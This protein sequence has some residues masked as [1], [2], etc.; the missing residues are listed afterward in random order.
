MSTLVVVVV[1]FM[2]M[3]MMMMM[4]MVKVMMKFEVHMAAKIKNMIF[5]AV[6]VAVF[7]DRYQ[8]FRETRRLHQ[9]GL[10]VTL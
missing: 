2:M 5:R 10:R 8:H 1:R 6:K 4:V 3:M 9:R 7:V